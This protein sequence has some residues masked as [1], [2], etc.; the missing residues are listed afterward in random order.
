M[1]AEWPPRQQVIPQYTMASSHY[2]L[3]R[4]P[5]ISTTGAP[6]SRATDLV[7]YCWHRPSY[8]MTSPQSGRTVSSVQSCGF[9][10]ERYV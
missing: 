8:L 10:W 2:G 6:V 4:C 1:L 9:Q 3:L 7:G 5:T